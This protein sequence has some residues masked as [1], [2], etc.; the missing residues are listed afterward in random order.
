MYYRYMDEKEL[1]NFLI[2][3]KIRLAGKVIFLKKKIK[4]QFNGLNVT[5]DHNNHNFK[6]L[7]DTKRYIL[8][9]FS[10]YRPLRSK[11]FITENPYD[12]NGTAKIKCYN[13]KAY[14]NRSARLKE[15]Y[16]NKD[17]KL[18]KLEKEEI[19]GILGKWSL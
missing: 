3:K 13:V 17:G 15:I 12:R 18:Q 19:N 14:S 7:L 1:K 10:F 5:F 8:V 4:V 9:A 6:D 11:D 2:G 16:I